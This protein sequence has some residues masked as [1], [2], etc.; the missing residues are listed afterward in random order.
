MIVIFVTSPPAKPF[1]STS[2]SGN[3]LINVG[4]VNPTSPFTTVEDIKGVVDMF[5]KGDYKTVH[6]VKEEQ[7][8]ETF[9]IS[10]WDEKPNYHAA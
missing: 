2:G 8:E 10:Q 5:I 9:I 1:N 3:T 4:A 7:I 6:T